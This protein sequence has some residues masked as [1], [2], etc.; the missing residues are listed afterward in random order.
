[1]CTLDF[2]EIY[3]AHYKRLFQVSYSITK[4]IYLAED[5]VQETFI[6]ALNKL[7]TIQVE[8]KLTSWLTVIAKRTA[9][10]V[11]RIERN[12]KGVPIEEDELVSI[13][14]EIN[15]NVEQEV[16]IAFL[17]EQVSE[18]I[19][20]LSYVY[21]DVMVLKVKYDLKIQEIASQLNINPSS[22]K[23]RI[24]RAR[25]QLKVLFEEEKYWDGSHT[26]YFSES[27][28]TVPLILNS[29]SE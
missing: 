21:Q 12:K 22:I 20:R 24:R 23:T 6:K 1:M 8:E 14:K 26:S 16:E 4:D 2:S 25:K 19:G 27:R 28:R 7:H 17:M 3:R 5:V 29:L 11:I 15:Q 13:G 9:I 18:A 10:D